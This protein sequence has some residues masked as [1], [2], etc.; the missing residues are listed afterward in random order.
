MKIK[1]RNERANN[2]RNLQE[3]RPF[4]EWRQDKSGGCG[5][6]KAGA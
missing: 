2:E 4:K 1:A 5:T 3:S 6:E